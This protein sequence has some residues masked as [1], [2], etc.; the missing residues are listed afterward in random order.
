MEI[1]FGIISEWHITSNTAGD[2]HSMTILR[3]D[4]QREALSR[5]MVDSEI[6]GKQLNLTLCPSK[7]FNR[8]KPNLELVRVRRGYQH[9]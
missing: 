9:L 7:P 3:L 2:N 8:S 5:A 4:W 1:T 6:Y